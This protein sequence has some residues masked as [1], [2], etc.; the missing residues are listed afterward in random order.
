MTRKVSTSNGTI[1]HT[2]GAR[3][4]LASPPRQTNLR[5]RPEAATLPAVEPASKGG[6]ASR[7]DQLIRMLSARRGADLAA[8]SEKFGW[9]SHT[10]RAALSGLRKA[11]YVVITEKRA[12]GKPTRYRVAAQTKGAALG[13]G[14]PSTAEASAPEAPPYPISDG[15]APTPSPVASL[16]ADA[17]NV[18]EPARGAA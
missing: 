5:V 14:V 6:G 12:D 15:T 2:E 17:D 18:S 3:A 8:I 16:A 1:E 4:E 11:G 13:E 10:T 9:L 7:R